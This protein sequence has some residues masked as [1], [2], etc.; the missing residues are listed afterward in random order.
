MRLKSLLIVLPVVAILFSCKAANEQAADSSIKVLKKVTI[1]WDANRE[2]NVNTTGGGYIVYYSQTKNFDI[3]TA[4]SVEV[5]YEENKLSAEVELLSGSTYYVK[6]AAYSNLDGAEYI[7]KPS[8]E[9]TL[10]IK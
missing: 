4:D 9:Q 3:S 2:K 1:S 8:T 5:T 10:E 7:S 6:V